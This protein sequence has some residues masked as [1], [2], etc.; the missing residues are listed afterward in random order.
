MKIR[1]ITLER[2]RLPLEPAFHAAWDPQPREYFD[3]TLVFVDTDEG[4]RGVG[5]GDTMDGFENFTSLFLGSDPLRIQHHVEVLE[6]INF[7]AA[8]YWPFEAALWDIIGQAAGLP[9]SVL[10]GGTLD[11][12]PVY[13][14][15]GSLLEPSARVEVAQR[16]HDE[17]FRAMKI[18][19]DPVALDQ[20]LASIRGVREALG[21]Q[22]EIMVDLNQGWRMPGDV[23]PRLDLRAARRFASA[24]NELDVFWLEE[25]LE[26]H[27]TAGHASLRTQSGLR[28]AGGEMARDVNEL[29]AHLDADS[30]DVYQP[31]AMLAVGMLRARFI[32]E[33]SH[34]KNRWFTPHSWTNGLGLLA[35]AA[36][37]AG[38]GG[39]PFFEFPYDPPGWTTERRDFFLVDKLT[40][41]DDGYFN[42]PDRPGLG[43]ILDDD[44]RRR[45]R[46]EG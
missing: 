18:R 32:A 8:R 21:A 33:L 22:M 45:W 6:S 3:A 2:L 13:A 12:L 25:P 4:L 14:S 7:H 27:D 36:V 11:R 39:G 15:T 30:L 46:R 1:A 34:V 29:L 9:V 26:R 38:V 44:A 23:T 37:S 17:G 19:V 16:L 10:F 20:G 35:N 31:D 40:I 28:I 24:L 42:L 41:D 43:A 5:S